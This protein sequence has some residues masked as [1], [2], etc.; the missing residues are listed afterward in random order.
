[1]FDTIVVKG[2]PM[3]GGL[4][5]KSKYL[6]GLQCPKYLWTVLHEPVKIPEP[7]AATQYIFDQGHLVGELAKRLF[8]GGIDVPAE[9]FNSNINQTREL[10]RQRKPLFEAGICIDP[11][12][13]RIDILDPVGKDNW[14]II[15]VKSSTSLKDINIHDVSF[16]KLCCEKAG[17]RIRNCKL[18]YIN[19]RYVLNGEIDPNEFF[20]LEDISTQ[21]EEVSEGIEERVLNLLELILDK[22][23]PEVDIGKHCLIPY[24]CMLRPKCWEFLPEN[25]IFDLRGG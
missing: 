25:S 3:K 6:N 1:M 5:T 2:I 14:D 16:Q 11:L 7:D 10:L 18:T 20:I 9:D 21:V 24:D 4:L 23:C 15:E 22:A 13:S 19:S 8:P 17:L 12:Y